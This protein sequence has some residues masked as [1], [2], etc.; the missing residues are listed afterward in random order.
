V[1]RLGKALLL[2]AG[3]LEVAWLWWLIHLAAKLARP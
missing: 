3:V 1:S 2:I